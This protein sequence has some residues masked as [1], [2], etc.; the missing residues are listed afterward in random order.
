MIKKI[1]KIISIIFIILFLIISYLSIFGLKTTKFNN[2]IKNKILEN[3]KAINLDLKAVTM[4][5]SLLDLKVNFETRDAQIIINNK[6]IDLESLKTKI[7]LLKLFKKQFSI[8]NLNLSSKSIKVNN[9]I[10]FIRSFN[11]DPKLFFLGMMVKSGDLK[12]NIDLNFDKKG[13]IK[14]DYKINGFVENLDIKI[15]NNYSLENL[16]FIFDIKDKKYKFLKLDTQF[17]KIKLNSP[18]IEIDEKDNSYLVEGKIL[19]NENNI[20]INL[21]QNLFSTASISL[22]L[23]TL[24]LV[25]ENDF[26]FK[27]SKK[28]KLSD[29]NINSEI[30]LSK[31][32][33]KN[34]FQSIK[35]YFPEIKELI[36]LKD[37]KIKLNYNKDVTKIKGTGK[38]IIEDNEDKISYEIIKKNNQYYFKNLFEIKKNLFFINEINY[39]KEKNKKSSI[40]IDGTLSNNKEINFNEISLMENDNSILIKNL[41]LDNK[42][43]ISD[44][45]LLE[46]DYKNNNKIQNQI[47]LK[48][49]KN[50]YFLV[51]N[52]FDASRIINQIME[53]EEDDSSIFSNLSSKINVKIKKT[54]IDDVYFINNLTGTIDYKNNK[55]NNLN[56]ESIFPNKKKIIL[57]IKTNKKDEKITT[58]FTG[59]PKPLIKR[60]K[61]IKGFEEG[62]LDFYS[63]K[64]NGVSNSSLVIDNFKVKEVPVLAK[65]LSLASLQGIA[66]LLTGEGIRFTDFEMK[67]QNKKGLM[68]IEDMYALGPAISILMDGYIETKK[69]ISLRGTLV[70]ATTI[71]RSISSIPLL[72]KILIGDKAG[73]GIFGVSFKIKGP[74]KNLKTTVNPIKSLTP[75]F[76]TRTLE[77]IKVD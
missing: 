15:L 27:L 49:R 20:P 26:S 37:H 30:N 28:F 62:Y 22:D 60:Y 74:P 67:F 45:D 31:L 9:L 1:I 58:F 65:L 3:N 57:A 12:G 41:N 56:L 19:S 13:L 72:G 4:T 10:T 42:F 36:N 70:P 29:L 50:D 64:K 48:K 24:N 33:Y 55:I 21:I 68:I 54:Y 39:K 40:K 77:K 35:K 69:L 23:Q 11:K 61:F 63:I 14:N 44:I 46:L 2:Q 52:S 47:Y 6:N 8:D 25:S 73:E 43:K 32:T 51:G 71:N 5:L 53:N 66:D 59:F 17:N 7:S 76:I 75:R 34:N 38:I 18:F 16:S